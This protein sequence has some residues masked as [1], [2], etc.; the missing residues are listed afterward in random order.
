MPIPGV[1]THAP[2]GAAPWPLVLLEGDEGAGKSFALAQFSRS[3]RIG[4]MFWIPLGEGGVAEQYGAIPGA[5][6]EVVDL[7]SGD[8]LEVIAVVRT[9]SSRPATSGTQP[10][11]GGTRCRPS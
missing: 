3:E 11:P 2:S 7:D 1:K 6:Y 8:Y 4:E 10:T 9:R 5:R